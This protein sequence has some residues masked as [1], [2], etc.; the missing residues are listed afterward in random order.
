MAL[1]VSF[2]L[3]TFPAEVDNNNREVHIIGNFKND[4]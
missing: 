2:L 4:E 3:K 1:S